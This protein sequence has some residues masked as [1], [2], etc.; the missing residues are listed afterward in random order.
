MNEKKHLHI[1]QLNYFQCHRVFRILNHLFTI[2]MRN[3]LYLITIFLNLPPVFGQKINFFAGTTNDSI[4]ESVAICQLDEDNSEI[5]LLNHLQGGKRPGYIVV[6]QDKKNLY[7]VSSQKF[8]D[9]NPT[10]SVN[11]FLIVDQGLGLKLLNSRTSKGLN[12]CHV[13]INPMKN[14]V[15]AANYN[16]GNIVCYKT[17]KRGR[18]SKPLCSIQHSG[19]GPVTGRQEG[20]HA[21]YIH[22]SNDGRFVYAADL[23]IDRI[24]IYK[25]EDAGKLIPNPGQEFLA[26]TP[27][28]G[29]RHMAFHA[30]EKWVFI[31]TELSSEVIS[32]RVDKPTG[33][34]EVVD[35]KKTIE[36]EDH[37]E[38]FPA[39]I[40][41]HPNGKYLYCSN[42]GA[43]S[44]VLFEISED[45]I[46][47]K[48]MSFRE[49]IGTVR[50]FNISP[51]GN[52]LIAGNQDRNELVLFKIDSDGTLQSTGSRIPTMEPSCVVFMEKQEED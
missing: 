39:A 13:S 3:L 1:H 24:M 6:A 23:G 28:S 2:F 15:Y 30:N 16:S 12:P 50:D 38:N 18:L 32:C 17:D 5:K 43:N 19:S 34:L 45:G 41:I 11:A 36:R 26:L 44:I 29:P 21:H 51:S 33:R 47:T 10:H 25:Q 52:H 8:E 4:G 22:A 35:I 31:L 27:G 14:Y 40:R 42:R 37:P 9:K 20:P 7:A 48:K 46:L 49:N